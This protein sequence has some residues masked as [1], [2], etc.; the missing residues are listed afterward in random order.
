MFCITECIT[1]EPMK[2]TTII[3]RV[4]EKTKELLQQQAD[5]EG[6]SLSN[7]IRLTLNKSL[8]KKVK[9]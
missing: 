1:F 9:L 6:I 8:K 7:Y 5:K 4:E 2:D 3:I